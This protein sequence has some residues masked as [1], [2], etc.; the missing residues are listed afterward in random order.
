M[1]TAKY[2][3][4]EN[5]G[6]V[7]CL[8][9]PHHCL[10]KSGQTGICKVRTNKGG[11]LVSDN[12]GLLSAK[13]LDP[14]EKKPLFHYFPGSKILSIGSVGCNMHCF[15]CQNCEISQTGVGNFSFLKPYLPEE[16]V[17]EALLTP[18]NIGI[19]YTYNEP[20]IFY[21]YMLDVA[22]LSKSKGLNNVMVSNGY[23]EQEPLKEVIP[24]IDAFNIDL[25]AFT[26]DFYTKHTHSRLEPVKQTLQ[27]IKE[28]GKHLEITNL[29]IPG[30][31][32]SEEIFETMV[33]WI[34]NEL[35]KHTVLHLSKYFPKY[36]AKQPVTSVETLFRLKGIAQRYLN[37]TYLGN[38]NN[39]SST[40]CYNCGALLLSRA[41]YNTKIEGLDNKGNCLHCE[42]HIVEM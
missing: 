26:E 13:H 29:V 42:S 15:F 23:I 25:K 1:H 3:V 20:S 37:Y 35:G 27:C 30:L 8:L 7:K 34:A 39:T 24:L 38:V 4:Q 6:K 21:E 19:A 31:N 2:Y 9:C 32:D 33:E 41:N 22:K 10:L 17:T 36:Q 28:A 14:I 12:Y 5:E 18:E 40:Y 16:I 11:V